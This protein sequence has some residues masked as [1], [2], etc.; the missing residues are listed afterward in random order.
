M[1]K[2]L[3][4]V[5]AAFLAVGAA[6]AVQV[7]KKEEPKDGPPPSSSTSSKADAKKDDGKADRKDAPRK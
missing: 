1:N 4:A 7:F 5:A 6:H 2:L 3:A